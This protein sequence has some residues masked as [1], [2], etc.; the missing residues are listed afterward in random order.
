MR[1]I[2]F[3]SSHSPSIRTFTRSCVA[4][5]LALLCAAAAIGAYEFRIEGSSRS[6]ERGPIEAARAQSMRLGR[7]A[8]R[9]GAKSSTAATLPQPAASA[10]LVWRP[11][12][13]GD[14]LIGKL[15]LILAAV[16]ALF[17]CFVAFYARRLTSVLIASEAAAT[18][19]AGHDLLSGLPNRMLFT[20]ALDTEINRVARKG[21]KLAL[22]Y[23]DLDGFKEIND[24]FGHEAGDKLIVAV[25][26]RITAALRGG[27]K[28]ARFGG[29]EFAVML[30]EVQ[31]PRDA[32]MVC[33]RLFSAMQEPFDLG[34]R[35]AF[36]GMSIGIALHP[37]D[38]ADRDELMRRADLALYRAKNEGRGRFAFFESRM[39]DELR[40]RKTVEDELRQAIE[41]DQLALVYQ[42]IFAADRRTIVAAEALVRWP[43]P[44]RGMIMPDQF[45]GLAEDHG[46]IAPLG[47]W[48]LRRACLDANKWPDVKVAVNV[49]P[50]QFR[51]RDFVATV[52]RIL[53][54]TK[55]NPNLVELELT[56]NVIVENADEAEEAM[57][58]L[59][60]MGVSLALD[61]FGTGYSSL[62]YLRRFAFDKIKIDRSFLE[63]MEPTGESA[64]IVESMV[65][66][67]RALGLIVTA[68]G[69]ETD[70]Q[71]ML[72]DQMGCHQLQGYGLSRPISAEAFEQLLNRTIEADRP[73]SLRGAA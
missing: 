56:E 35:E 36:A 32:E 43:H 25:G 72:L 53:R 47:E 62:I 70:E 7:E 38:A 19:L 61:D 8:P 48:V 27:D 40:M 21:G 55:R 23:I 12:Q 42:P 26:Q 58:Q 10:S 39:G 34:E 20:S 1:P 50:I 24:Y 3:R 14:R 59:R 57:I 69:V 2:D 9:A 60:A 15:G 44:E 28:V 52:E 33:R 30:T 49:S 22:L 71:K 67:G 11:Q 65:G 18:R 46:L 31:S 68:E 17:A 41:Q 66:L 5:A 37:Q 16:S 63:S 51:S 45:I 4:V 64:I 13:P 6:L 73:R 54:E 29:D